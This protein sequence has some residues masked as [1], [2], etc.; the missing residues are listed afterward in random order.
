[1]NEA[2]LAY[3]TQGYKEGNMMAKIVVDESM[4]HGRVEPGFEEVREEFVRNFK[5]RGEI[6]AACAIY[7]EGKKV[8][9]LWG[10]Y[11]DRK[12][13]LP[14]EGDTLALVLSVSKGVCG[15]ALAIAHS[16]GLLDY[17]EKV[18]TYWPEFAQQGKKN[19]TVRQLIS[20]Q[21]GLAV[22][23]ERL[24]PKVLADLDAT[25]AAIAKQKPAWEPGTRHGYHVI[26]LGFFESELM[27]RIDP[28][29]RSISQ[30]I[31]D[32]LIGPLNE[33]EF[34]I[35]TPADIPEDRIA[36]LK[37]FAY[38]DTLSDMK[39]LALP[40]RTYFPAILGVMKPRIAIIRAFMLYTIKW[41][42]NLIRPSIRV[43]EIPSA[44]GIGQA[45]A[46]AKA[47]GVFAMGG[48]ELGI[49][50]ETMRELTAPARPPSKG[51]KDILIGVETRVSLGFMKPFPL[52]PF[53]PSD[54]AFGTPG[55]GGAFGYA[56][57]DVKI[58]YAYIPNKL[59]IVFPDVRDTALRKAMYRC[60]KKLRGDKHSDRYNRVAPGKI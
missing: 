9:D 40:L 18:A 4:I 6:G 37:D 31:Q 52:F 54:R 41:P 46:I 19:V 20:H 24:Y 58:G 1:M 3:F 28:Q 2:S 14:W 35:G 44:N 33:G 39:E 13:G 42:R 8:V 21:A 10:G 12:K 38:A 11:R 23:D 47:Y 25:A 49:R 51:S 60:V 22:I 7:H 30:F 36:K 45:R 16:R 34:Y 32:E 57:P 59:N 27:R 53:S 56:D 26:S 55:L 29:H 48:G 17:D 5:K 50:D 15:M 43:L